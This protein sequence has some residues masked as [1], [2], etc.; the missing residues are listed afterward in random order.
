MSD[1]A[2]SQSKR[3]SRRSRLYPVLSMLDFHPDKKMVSDALGWKS[4]TSQGGD[5]DYRE[6]VPRRATQSG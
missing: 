6:G 1:D 5:S 4:S 2:Q 3:P